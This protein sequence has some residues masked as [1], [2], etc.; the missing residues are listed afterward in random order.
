MPQ[1]G[2]EK[3]GNGVA[4]V[5][6]QPT[7]EVK[8]EAEKKTEGQSVDAKKDDTVEKLSK[9]EKKRRKRN[10]AQENTAMD[11]AVTKP[12]LV[13][14]VAPPNDATKTMFSC[15]LCCFR[16]EDEREIQKHFK[17]TQHR[18]IMRHLYGF[19]PK[20]SVNFLEEYLLDT[21]KN[22]FRE[23]EKRLEIEKPKSDN[24]R[25]IGQEHFLHRV[26]AAHCLA[27]DILI[28][29]IP[30]FLM[31]HIK[32]ALHG[33]N[34]RAANKEIKKNAFNA[35]TTIL[36]NKAVAKLLE[37]YN[38]GD[39]PFPDSNTKD[40]RA[41]AATAEV[42]TGALEDLVAEDDDDEDS[43]NVTLASS[44]G[45]TDVP[46]GMT[47]SDDDNKILSQL[48]SV[49]GRWELRPMKSHDGIEATSD[50]EAAEAI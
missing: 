49:T 22:V 28:P 30:N 16:S 19:L 7:V 14:T 17:S 24:F 25:G 23:R 8:K 13:N 33:Q 45:D 31:D 4:H 42:I 18:E 9:Q 1:G 48:Q 38:K 40:D 5:P 29:D 6:V 27:C 46:K 34:R 43:E 26:E 21:N 35:A 44:G 50:E 2:A 11:Q 3:T 41:E 32:S 37:R 36:S 20:L 15:N 47:F 39:S 10:R 12:A